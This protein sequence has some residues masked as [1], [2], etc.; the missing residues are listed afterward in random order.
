MP[1]PPQIQPPPPYPFHPHPIPHNPNPGRIPK[2]PFP[3]FDGENPR[4]WRTRCINNFEMYQTEPHMWV[5]VAHM[6]F[7][8]DA[9]RWWQL[10]ESTLAT[11][12]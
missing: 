4:L 6:H 12:S 11:A 1:H 8:G 10:F 3:K 2:L 9:A 5:R 7:E